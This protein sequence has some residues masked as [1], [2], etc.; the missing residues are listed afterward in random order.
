M[1]SFSLYLFELYQEEKGS[2]FSDEDK[3]YDINKIFKLTEHAPTTFEKIS[4]LDWII[5]HKPLSHEDKER[6]NNADLSV[7]ILITMKGTRVLV[8]DGYHRLL[9]AITEYHK[10]ILAKWVTPKI[11]SESRI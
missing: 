4:E 1:K 10:V 11:M 8:V 2:T 7:P 6:V 3:N 9:K 5:D